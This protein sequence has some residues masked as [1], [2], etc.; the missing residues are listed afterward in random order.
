MVKIRNGFVSNS[1][2]SS[3]IIA[4]P[5]DVNSRGKL[6]DLLFSNQ[7]IYPN[8]HYW[9]GNDTAGWAVSDVATIVWKDIDQPSKTKEELVDGNMHGYTPEYTM[10]ERKVCSEYGVKDIYNIDNKEDRQKAYELSEQYRAELSTNVIDGFVSNNPYCNFYMVEYSDNDGEM[11][12]AMEHGDL[13]DRIPH[14][15]ISHH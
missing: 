11:F 4:V 14:I 1:S 9:D 5:K 12:S 3:F 10:A 15:R 8:P 13:F 2:S 6:Q 7:V